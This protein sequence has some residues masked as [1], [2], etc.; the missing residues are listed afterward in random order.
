[1]IIKIIPKTAAH[2][3]PKNNP[4]LGGVENPKDIP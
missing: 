2:N 3:P 4:K 1:M